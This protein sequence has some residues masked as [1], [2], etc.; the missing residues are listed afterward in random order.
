MNRTWG[1]N[2]GHKMDW[3]Y[4][5]NHLQLSL[6]SDQIIHCVMLLDLSEGQV[7]LHS[8]LLAGSRLDLTFFSS[9]SLS[10]L[11][12]SSSPSSSSFESSFQVFLSTQKYQKFH[13]LYLERALATPSCCCWTIIIRQQYRYHLKERVACGLTKCIYHPQH[14]QALII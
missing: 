13:L 10:E 12:A 4:S 5:H 7:S 9:C 14:V 6:K 8:Y 1:V 11:L 3:T 2:T